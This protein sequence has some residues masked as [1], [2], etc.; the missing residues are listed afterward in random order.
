MYNI[1]IAKVYYGY[2]YRYYGWDKSFNVFMVLGGRLSCQI[3]II[4]DTNMLN[5]LNFNYAA[6]QVPSQSK[7]I[8][9]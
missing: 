2:Q 4:K 1:Y 7:F 9:D 6:Y 8:N 5:W 3:F